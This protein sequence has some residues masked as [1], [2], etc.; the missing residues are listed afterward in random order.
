MKW[1]IS[2][3]KKQPNQ[4]FKVRETL[5]FDQKM[6]A[7]ISNIRGVSDVKVN[8]LIKMDD[9]LVSVDLMFKGVLYLPCS[10][11]DE[12][13]DF[14]FN[15]QINELLDEEFVDAIDYEADYIDLLELAWQRL[16][17]EAPTKF[18]KNDCINKSGK[19]W[20]LLSEDEYDQEKETEIDPRLA[21]LE[22]L[23]KDDKE[24]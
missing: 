16:I 8:G 7:K 12:T 13:G 3:L 20:R 10:L 17:V 19:S 5:K 23:F 21:K 11:S 22:G 1:K 18:V 9:E 15:F 6:F 14:P 2:W 24:D 4:E